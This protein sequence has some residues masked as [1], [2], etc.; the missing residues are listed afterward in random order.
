MTCTKKMPNMEQ[1]LNV[2]MYLSPEVNFTLVL[3]TYCMKAQA[4]GGF[5]LKRFKKKNVLTF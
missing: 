3:A 5:I 1:L 2:N 4:Q